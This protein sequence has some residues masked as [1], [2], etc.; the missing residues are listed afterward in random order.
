[1]TTLNEFP[2]WTAIITPLNDDGS[3][4][5]E[6]YAGLLQEQNAAK[7]G[8]LVLGSTGESLNLTLEEKK[9]LLEFTLEQDLSVP[10]MVGV[11]GSNLE[12]TKSWIEYL[13]ELK[14]DALLMV[15]P[16]Y[17]KPESQGQYEWF[18]T[19]MDLANKPVMLYN[20]PS[21]T[22]K[23]LSHDTVKRLR[24]HR[25]FWALKEASGSAVEFEKYRKDAGEAK[26]LSG[27]DGLLPAFCNYGCN[28]LVS[29][30]SNAWP[31][32]THLYVQMA[33]EKRLSPEDA[34]LWDACSAALFCVSNPIPVKRLIAEEGRI[35]SPVLKLP[36]SHK[37]L[38]QA[39]TVAEASTR[40]RSW[41]EK[42]K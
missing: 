1:M 30:A 37:D 18:K 35:K 36:L 26:V 20:V 2:L 24:E 9:T 41:Y 21:R 14:I 15:T 13:N 33:L 7:N 12:T 8:I 38:S 31:K 3:L 11:P 39:A 40:I 16:L 23:E 42:N 34:S 28:G 29:V 19:L 4:D 5:L 25:N 17:A 10:L 22:G 6:S 27:D 32:A